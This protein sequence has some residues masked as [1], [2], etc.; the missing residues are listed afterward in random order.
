LCAEKALRESVDR[1]SA[2]HL[3]AGLAAH[4]V[5]HREERRLA[6][7]A[8][9]I[10]VFVVLANVTRVGTCRRLRSQP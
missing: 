7:L 2:G 1:R 9:E 5:G 10:A 8:D 4:A 3:S 6:S